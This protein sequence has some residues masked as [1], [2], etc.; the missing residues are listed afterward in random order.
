MQGAI[1]LSLASLTTYGE[2]Y[3]HWIVCYSGGKDSSATASFAIWAITNGL[4]PAPETLTILYADTRM[5]LEPLWV[6]ARS[7]MNAASIKIG[8][9]LI[10]SRQVLPALDNRFFVYLLG[11]GVPPP[12]NTFRWCTERIKIQPMEA[13]IERLANEYASYSIFGTAPR[14]LQLTGVRKGESAARDQRIALA[15]SKKDG[16]CGQGWFQIKPPTQVADSLAPLLHWRTCFVWD[17]LYLYAPKHGFTMLGE[18]AEAY[19]DDEGR[20]GC[21][22]CNLA[23]RDT[24]LEN[25]V[26]KPRWAHLKPLLEL[27]PLYAELKKAKWR[28]R[29][30]EPETLKDGSLSKS[31]QRL[32]PLTMEGRAYGLERV[33]DI[34][35]RASVDLIDAQEEARIRELWSLGVYPDRWGVDDIVGDTPINRIVALD[36]ELIVQPLLSI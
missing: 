21:V 33:L 9:T 23:S 30:A 18:I 28:L 32:G 10:Q 14:F 22:G 8:G 13:E 34:Q 29:K 6:T 3:K 5:E 7:F 27:K 19:G 25:L 26:K 2:R 24:A 12:S 16:E 35:R 4:V 20:T 31:G 15:C 17:W 36:D 1:D 11:R